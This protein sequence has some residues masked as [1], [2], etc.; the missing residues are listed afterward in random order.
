ME[1]VRAHFIDLLSEE[2]IAMLGDMAETVLTHLGEVA[3]SAGRLTGEDK[4][5]LS[6]LRPGR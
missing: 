1:S 4:A 3:A 2:Q 6:N 5:R